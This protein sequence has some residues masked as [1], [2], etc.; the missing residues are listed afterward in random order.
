MRE[1]ALQQTSLK[2]PLSSLLLS[3]SI[4]QFAP[5]AKNVIFSISNF[6]K[7]LFLMPSLFGFSLFPLLVYLRSIIAKKS[8]PNLSLLK[9]SSIFFPV[10][11]KFQTLFLKDYRDNLGLSDDVTFLLERIYFSFCQKLG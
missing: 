2:S 1:Y 6:P 11:F 7:F 5:A 8:L 9:F 3:M 10:I 4:V